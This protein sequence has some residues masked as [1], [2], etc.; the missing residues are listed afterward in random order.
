LVYFAIIRYS[1]FA[2][3]KYVGNFSVPRPEAAK[4]DGRH[5]RYRIVPAAVGRCAPTIASWDPILQKMIQARIGASPARR[6]VVPFARM[7]AVRDEKSKARAMAASSGRKDCGR[8]LVGAIAAMS[9]L[10]RETLF[11]ARRGIMSER[12]RALFSYTISSIESARSG[13]AGA[14]GTEK[15]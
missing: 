5:A 11:Q 15:G 13:S 14:G 7:E 9:H 10:S 8:I 3:I 4:H 1:T 12:T 6:D 2:R